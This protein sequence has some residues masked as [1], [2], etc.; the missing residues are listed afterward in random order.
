MPTHVNSRHVS[1]ERPIRI[2]YAEFLND[3]DGADW[4]EPNYS[5]LNRSDLNDE[6]II[7]TG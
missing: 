7:G 2:K 3:S 6:E 4:S 5:D 1:E